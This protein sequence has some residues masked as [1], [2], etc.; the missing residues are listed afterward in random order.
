MAYKREL[1]D[2]IEQFVAVLDTWGPVRS[3]LDPHPA[4]RWLD[5]LAVK[6]LCGAVGEMGQ[7]LVFYPMDTVKIQC[8]AH[9]LGS[10]AAWA[11]IVSNKFHSILML[12]E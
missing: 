9:S 8:Q 6:A 1:K 2:F 10:R 7:I 3:A 12:L 5:P 11:S 4:L